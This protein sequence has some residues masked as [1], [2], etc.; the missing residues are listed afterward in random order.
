[1]KIR[2]PK[3][4]K[5]G[6]D[7]FAVKIDKKRVDADFSYE[8]QVL[9]IGTKINRTD[10]LLN[11]ISHELYEMWAVTLYIR[12]TRPDTFNTYEFHFDHRQFTNW[13]ELTT[14]TLKEFIV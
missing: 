6:S 13:V 3:Q 2:I 5:I 10:H 7:I 12:Y 4:I 11:I 9:T 14:Q 8:T 1:M